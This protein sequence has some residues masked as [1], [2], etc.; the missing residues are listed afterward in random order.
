VVNS[1]SRLY[2]AGRS[3]W[4]CRREEGD[5]GR[6]AWI[7]DD[8]LEVFDYIRLILREI[9]EELP[10]GSRALKTWLGAA[11]TIGA[12]EKLAR[13]DHSFAG[14]DADLEPGELARQDAIAKWFREE[15]ALESGAAVGA[16]P[17]RES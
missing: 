8:T 14:T 5:D 10:P 13:S 2:H 11:A 1:R 9:A 6:P 17:R 16:P 15:S 7:P 3:K 12:V 4:F